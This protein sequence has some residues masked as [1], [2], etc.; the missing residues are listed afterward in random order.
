MS[1]QTYTGGKKKTSVQMKRDLIEH[2]R[3]SGKNKIEIP[4]YEG[5]RKL[6][7]HRRLRMKV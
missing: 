6:Q 1:H 7:A 3:E 4:P 2:Y 5:Y